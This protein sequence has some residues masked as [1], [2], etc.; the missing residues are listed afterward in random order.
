VAKASKIMVLKKGVLP[1]ILILLLAGAGCKNQTTATYKGYHDLTAR[2]NR[3]FN[4]KLIFTQTFQQI[5]EQHQDDYTDILPLYLYHDLESP[6]SYN[7]QMDNVIKKESANLQLHE[8]SKWSDDAYLHIGMANYIK[9]NFE[10]ALKAFKIIT[11]EYNTGVRKKPSKTDKDRTRGKEDGYNAYYNGTGSF[12]KHKPAR[13]EAI[14]W[15]VRT[16]AQLEKFSEAQSVLA[17]ARGDKTYPDQLKSEL[18][19]TGAF[20]H[21]QQKNYLK[22]AGSIKKAIEVSEDK[23][24]Q[25]VKKDKNEEKKKGTEKDGGEK[26]EG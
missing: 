19:K 6:Q 24:E 12:L 4:S 7:P 3:Y 18:H 22:A 1:C 8:N 17:L 20:L 5:E 14:L 10:E 26:E 15:I 16:Y 2:Y 11:S 23:K 25:R 13:Y 21:L 9:G